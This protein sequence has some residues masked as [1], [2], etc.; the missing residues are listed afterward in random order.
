MSRCY[1]FYRY[2]YAG[3]AIRGQDRW[4]AS[5]E[6]VLPALRRRMNGVD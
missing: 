3:V 2:R 6:V 4:I 5:E 1:R